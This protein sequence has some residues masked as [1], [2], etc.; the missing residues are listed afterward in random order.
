MRKL[1]DASGF[2]AVEK[3]LR[4]NN[5]GKNRLS[6]DIHGQSQE[7]DGVRDSHALPSGNKFF[8]SL[9]SCSH[10]LHLSFPLC[11]ICVL[12][13]LL[14]LS[15]YLSLSPPLRSFSSP[16]PSASLSLSRHAL[17][18]YPGSQEQEKTRAADSLNSFQAVPSFQ[19]T[20]GQV[21]LGARDKDPG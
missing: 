9:L 17:S 1:K 21:L 12:Q 19:S 2:H 3:F 10:S 13:S 7:A 18:C 5:P 20:S 6:Q 8:L 4:K 16:P 14:S 15:V 11:L